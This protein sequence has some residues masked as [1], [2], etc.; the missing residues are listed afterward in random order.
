[1]STYKALVVNKRGSGKNS[2]TSVKVQRKSIPKL[3]ESEVEIRT[4]YSSVNYKDALATTP[5][6][7]FVKK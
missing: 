1:M 5:T 6:A 3:K 4:E 2:T 7:G